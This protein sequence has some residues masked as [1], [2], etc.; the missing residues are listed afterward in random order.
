MQTGLASPWSKY[1][2]FGKPLHWLDRRW[3]TEQGIAEAH[4][5]GRLLREGGYLDIA[6]TSVLRRSIKTLRIVLEELGLEWI[7]VIKA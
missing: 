4:Q 3:A 6:Y 5:T 1:L 7:P 2:E